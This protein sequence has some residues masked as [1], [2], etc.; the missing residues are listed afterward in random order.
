MLSAFTTSEDLN[1]QSFVFK[2]FS[3]LTKTIRRGFQ[4]LRFE[5]HFR[6][7]PFL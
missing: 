5:E 4:F 7:V 2:M 3:V 1:T 6:K